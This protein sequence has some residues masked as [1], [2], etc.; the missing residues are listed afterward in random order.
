MIK[1]YKLI[2]NGNSVIIKEVLKKPC[3]FNG[4]VIL[5]GCEPKRLSL[6]RI[7]NTRKIKYN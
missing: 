2:K 7:K 1:R 3:I 4:K 6:S 5:V